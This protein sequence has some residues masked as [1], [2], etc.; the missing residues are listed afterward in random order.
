MIN[1]KKQKVI[2]C[3]VLA[4]A[5]FISCSFGM[6]KF[7]A[8]GLPPTV[9]TEDFGKGKPGVEVIVNK[10]EDKRKENWVVEIHFGTKPKYVEFDQSVDLQGRISNTIASELERAGFKVI[11][12]E[13]QTDPIRPVLSGTIVRYSAVFKQV[14]TAEISLDITLTKGDNVLLQE[15]YVS[16]EER[17]A[18]ASLNG[19]K[20]F[21]EMMRLAWGRILS[22]MIP[23]IIETINKNS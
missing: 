6:K 11:R 5:L 8:V 21:D 22:Q 23:E 13:N 16:I 4:A 19:P 18:Q 1:V 20:I 14:H 3:L 7:E 2:M 17:K 15:T 10:L 12:G 9:L